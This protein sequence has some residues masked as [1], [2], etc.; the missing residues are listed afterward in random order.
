MALP[1]VVVAVAVVLAAAGIG[2]AQVRCQDAARAGAR[3]L[4][5]GEGGAA[6]AAA[7]TVLAPGGSRT[8][9]VE[10][11]EGTHQ[12]QVLVPVH[13]LGG[14]PSGRWRVD[15]DCSATSWS[16]AEP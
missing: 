8:S 1:V 12:V 7:V 2:S 13:P 14:G 6:A 16:E 11:G 9:L 4:A 3:V 5:R 15:V 10:T